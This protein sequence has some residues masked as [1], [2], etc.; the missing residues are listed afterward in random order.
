MIT[1]IMKMITLLNIAILL[2]IIV[3]MIMTII[4]ISTILVMAIHPVSVRRFPSFRTR[5]LENLSHY[6]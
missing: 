3:V 4:M 6:L 5:L 2:I 1:M